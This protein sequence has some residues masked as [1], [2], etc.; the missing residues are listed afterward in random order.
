[1][2]R[3][4]VPQPPVKPLLRATERHDFW[5]GFILAIIAGVVLFCGVRHVTGV[6][7]QEGDSASELQLVRSFTSGGL[8]F[9]QP[10]PPPDPARFDDPGAAAE[11]LERANRVA[12]LPLRARYRVNTTAADPCPT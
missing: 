10:G 7:T 1:M 12:D 4:C 11:A 5:T 9:A 3:K 8:H 2:I 6:E